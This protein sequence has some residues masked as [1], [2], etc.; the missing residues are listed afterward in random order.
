MI[1]TVNFRT[2]G[3]RLNHAESDSLEFALQ[4]AGYSVVGSKT[5]AD[6]TIINS[7]AVTKQ[8]E[9]KT[10]GAIAA[11]RRI[12]PGGKIA[13]IGCYSQMSPE[14]V[15]DIA[16]VNL[17]LG[18]SE[19]YQ[20]IDFLKG[21]ERG[22]REIHVSGEIG[23]D[24]FPKPGWISKGSR[25]RA[26]LKIQEGCDYR[27]SYCIIPLLRGP[28]RSR[29]FQNCIDEA[30]QLAESGFR[31]IVLTGVNIGTYSDG[32]N[33][34]SDLIEAILSAG[35][36]ERLRISSIEPD[37]VTDKLIHLMRSEPRICRH[38]HI[39]LQHGS[40]DILGFMRRRYRKEQFSALISKIYDTVPGICIGTDVMVGFPGETEHHFRET[41]LLLEKMPIAY[42]HVFRYSP[43]PGTVTKDLGNSVPAAIKKERAESLRQLSARKRLNY[44]Q[45]FLNMELS[46]LFEK[47]TKL[48]L[49]RGLSDNYITVN[50]RSS[51]NIVNS[52]Q[53]VWITDVKSTEVLGELRGE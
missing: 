24:T 38:F 21:L 14:L 52:I 20:V 19:K 5:P 2:L 6:L 13:V 1:K 18:N 41:Y 49:Y 34:L 50:V 31:E 8:A 33:D 27:C 7:C 39:P 32:S 46:V 44:R 10:R 37:L 51:E 48:G 15:A 53:T 22:S 16:G 36:V 11:A 47:K 9:A 3:C 17:V 23:G 35:R 25:T 4:K 42:F 43:R 40:N 29:N 26:Y 12:S 28:A 45:R 30:V